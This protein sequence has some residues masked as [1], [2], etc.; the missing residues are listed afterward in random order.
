[1]ERTSLPSLIIVAVLMAHAS[2]TA[3]MYARAPFQLD[4][5]ELSEEGLEQQQAT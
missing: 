3:G 4:A 1:M 2:K 5:N